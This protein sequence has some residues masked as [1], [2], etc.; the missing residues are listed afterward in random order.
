MTKHIDRSGDRLPKDSSP[1]DAC[2]DLCRRLAHVCWIGGSPCAGKSSVVSWLAERH[3]FTSYN[4]DDAFARHAGQIAAGRQPAFYKVTHMT[5]DELWMRPVETLLQDEIAVYGEEWPIIVDDL[6]SLPDDRPVVAEG[7][8]LM[9]ALVAPVLA[10]PAQAIWVVP[11]EDFQRTHYPAR[12]EW[13][14]DIVEQCSDPE[15][16]LRNWMDR[17]VAFARLVARH[18]ERLGLALLT[19]DGSRTVAQNAA[20]VE[21]HFGLGA[22]GVA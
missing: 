6:L 1:S 19:V 12:G 15:R 14:H 16:A 2:P 18:A 21:A 17:D 22:D 20:L 9:P 5:W 4:C 10:R 11:S 3:A 8:A 13:V 7:A